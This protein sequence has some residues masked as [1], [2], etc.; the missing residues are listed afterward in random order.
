MI[1]D[2]TPSRV[3]VRGRYVYN[4]ETQGP[5]FDRWLESERDA[6]RKQVSDDCIAKMREIESGVFDGPLEYSVEKAR[7]FGR[8]DG[9]FEASVI[10][11]N[12]RP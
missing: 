12:G 3:I 11:Q 4:E 1:A 7:R 9:L 10:A 8:A 6:V 2:Y 5:E